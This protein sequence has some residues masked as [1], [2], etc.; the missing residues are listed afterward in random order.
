M[1][2][3]YRERNLTPEE[4]VVQKG[5]W[6]S[7]IAK[8]KLGH[9]MSWKEIAAVNNISSAD[10]IES[11]QKL[12]IYTNLQGS[13][14][15][16]E[17]KAQKNVE[18][19]PNQEPK[20]QANIQEESAVQFAPPPPGQQQAKKDIRP[21]KKSKYNFDIAKIIQQNMFFITIGW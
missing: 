19:L 3:F 6:L 18:P 21:T 15:R 11:G 7:T 1:N 10:G 12:L 16:L 17:A 4:Y 20:Q 5:D 14:P 8:S 2:S 13:A 9:P